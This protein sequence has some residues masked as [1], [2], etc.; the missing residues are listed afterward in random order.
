MVMVVTTIIY[1]HVSV[2]CLYKCFHICRDPSHNIHRWPCPRIIITDLTVFW[3]NVV[4]NVALA[5]SNIS[6]VI[7]LKENWTIFACLQYGGM[8]VNHAVSIGILSSAFVL[9]QIR[10]VIGMFL[11]LI[12]L[13]DPRTML[14][15]AITQYGCQW[16]VPKVT[17]MGHLVLALA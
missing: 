11:I 4:P 9:P 13:Q 8:K 3:I 5:T 12:W 15:F 14:R 6:S 17:S 7:S 10:W 1:F 16:R 2:L